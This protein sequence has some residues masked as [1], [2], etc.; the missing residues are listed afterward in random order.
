MAF[1]DDEDVQIHLPV[2]KLKVEEIPDDLDA[3]KEYGAR[4]IRAYLSPVLEAA[5]IALW[6]DPASTPELIR[7]INGLLTASKIY[8]DRY[9]EDALDDPEFAQQKYNEAMQYL[10][11]LVAGQ[12]VIDGSG[13]I[14]S[15]IDDTWFQPNDGSTDQP[16]FT[17]SGRY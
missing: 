8:R 9:S 17:M 16:K 12:I 10:N 1:V 11:A 3:A 2:D 6:V 13:D 7:L 5:T 14:T 15:Q 4:I